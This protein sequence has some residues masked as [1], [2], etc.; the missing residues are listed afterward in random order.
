MLY[1]SYIVKRMLKKHKYIGERETY[2]QS[3]RLIYLE[4]NDEISSAGN[5]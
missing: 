3:P 2:D 5:I 1:Y 4:Q